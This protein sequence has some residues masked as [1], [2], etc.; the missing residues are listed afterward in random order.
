[1]RAELPVAPDN[2]RK[3]VPLPAVKVG[4]SLKVLDMEH[5]A[6]IHAANRKIVDRDAF[7]EDVRREYSKPP[8]SKCMF[9]EWW[10]E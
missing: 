4:K 7:E 2:L 8:E 3:P 6:A 5:R 10:C 1:M 9:F